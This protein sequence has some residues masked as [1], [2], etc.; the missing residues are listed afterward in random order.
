MRRQARRREAGVGLL[1]PPD[2]AGGERHDP[3]DGQHALAAPANRPRPPSPSPAPLSS[4]RPTQ[5]LPPAG[6]SSYWMATSPTW[7]Q[8]S[9][10]SS[11]ACLSSNAGSP[12]TA[13]CTSQWLQTS[14]ISAH[15]GNVLI[16]ASFGL[17][18]NMPPT[19]DLVAVLRTA[20]AGSKLR[21]WLE[22]CSPGSCDADP[23]IWFYFGLNYLLVGVFGA[24][25]NT[26]AEIRDRDDGAGRRGLPRSTSFC[27]ASVWRLLHH[28]QRSHGLARSAAH[29]TT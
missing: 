21:Y 16:A 20:G 15:P 23:H 3:H 11:T 1:R 8:C 27:T 2:A 24:G 18:G 29:P 9:S 22:H 5:G 14:S 4:P 6:A 17:G 26:G 7:P 13:R 28:R 25:Q 12:T 10:T 19:D